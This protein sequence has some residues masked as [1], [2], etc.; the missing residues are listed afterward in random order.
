MAFDIKENLKKLP[1]TPGVYIHKDSLGQVIYVGKAVNLKRRVSGYFTNSSSHTSKVRRMVKDISEFEYINCQTEMEALILECNLIKKYQPRYNILLRDDKT[2]PYIKVTV[3]EE[4]PRVIKTRV[5]ERDGARYFGPYSD[6]TAV[7]NIIELLN[8][9]YTLKRCS[10][11]SFNENSR[12]CLNYHIQECRGVCTG[13][14]CREEYLKDID[15]VL[16]FLN[17]RDKKLIGYLK[18]KMQAKAENLEFEEAAVYR[19]YLSSA[20]S[21]KSVQRVT[22][23][24]GKDFDMVLSAG[25]GENISAVLFTV[26]D[27]KLGGR[28][29]FA[30]TSESEMTSEQVVEEF[31]KQYYRELASPPHEIV[32][33]KPLSQSRLIEDYLSELGGHK[34]RIFTP[35]RGDKKALLELA[36]RDVAQMSETLEARLDTAREKEANI[37]KLL[38]GL[39]GI[40]KE[41]Y[42]VESYDISNTNGVDT[43][44]AMVVYRNL[45]PVRKD[46][47]RFRIR[48]V[49][50][51]DDYASLEEM[52]IRRFNR[53]KAND[54]GF[55]NLPDVIFIDGGLGQVHS[56][57]KAMEKV[58]IF[59]PVYGM[60]KD[61]SHRTRALIDSDGNELELKEYGMLF[62]YLGTIQ[63]EV[64]RFAIEYHRSLHNRNSIG[65]VLDNIPGI[66]P[67]KRTALLTHF[68]SVDDIRNAD[69]EALRAVD[70]ISEKNA[71]EI[72]RYFSKA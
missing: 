30:M 8:K 45:K 32:V 61:D 17:G 23:V 22:M 55:R 42:R 33:S 65:S 44:G 68:K 18:E 39:T 52:L 64:H 38:A 60:A 12:P 13:K 7:N 41:Y 34:V 28:E 71:E 35:E 6:V 27:G 69:K 3:N 47:R 40:E 67:K 59:V 66:G 20:E 53:A 43:V 5:Q 72:I 63:E 26:R 21:L 62:S 14:V 46:Y 29:T 4:Y 1:E 10:L 51:P 15:A 24:N 57:V 50:G 49:T 54:P 36:K 48:S 25:S 11:S 16:D 9:I 37:R 56:A 31:I 70:G 19:D 2:Y 58:G